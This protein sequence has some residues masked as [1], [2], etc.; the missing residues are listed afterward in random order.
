MNLPQTVDESS[1]SVAPES[2]VRRKTA[3]QERSL[4]VREKAERALLNFL[5]KHGFGPG[6]TPE[7]VKRFFQA[8][9]NRAPLA[10]GREVSTERV[11]QLVGEHPLLNS[12]AFELHT[13][14]GTKRQARSCLVF[15]A[16]AMV[17]G[18][19]ERQLATKTVALFDEVA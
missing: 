6:N 15:V 14:E 3:T 18:R 11:S 16:V 17:N 19:L 7:A 9:P 8:W 1:V 5:A 10:Y 12:P 2:G 13:P 4:H